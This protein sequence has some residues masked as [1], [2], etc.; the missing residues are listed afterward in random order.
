LIGRFSL[1]R[2]VAEFERHCRTG[3]AEH[4][5][6]EGVDIEPTLMGGT[7]DA[8][9]DL[10]GGGAVPGPIAAAHFACDYGGPQRLLG[11]PVRGID[12]HRIEQEG[13]ERW[14]FNGEMR[15]ES[16]DSRHRAGMIETAIEAIHQ[17]PPG[18]GETVRGD[19]PPVVAIAQRE[20]LVEQRAHGVHE[21][22]ARM[23]GLQQS[24][25]SEQMRDTSGAPRA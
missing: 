23:I 13:E 1:L 16:L 17:M 15:R 24:A 10:L 21:A 18:D 9:E 4:G 11:A 14:E 2:P 8:R 19:A 3:S 5:D 7:E 22:G 25:A 12:G 20:R 6:H